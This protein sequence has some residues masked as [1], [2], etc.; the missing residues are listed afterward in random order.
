MV[1][2]EEGKKKTKNKPNL[3]DGFRA[4]LFDERHSNFLSVRG[5]AP[6]AVPVA[7]SW[8]GRVR[9]S[10]GGGDGVRS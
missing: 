10:P 5:V 7:V 8:R 6:V 1:V 4:V 2:I 9:E 3:H